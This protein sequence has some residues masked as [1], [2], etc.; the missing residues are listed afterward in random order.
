MKYSLSDFVYFVYMIAVKDI[1]DIEVIVICD[2]FF[3]YDAFHIL[4]FL[5]QFCTITFYVSYSYILVLSFL[6]ITN[7]WWLSL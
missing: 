1:H 4:W 6:C 2:V 5:K 3:L 7:L